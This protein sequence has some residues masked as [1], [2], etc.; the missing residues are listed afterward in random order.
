MESDEQLKHW[1]ALLVSW[2]N[3]IYARLLACL[4]VDCTSLTWFHLHSVTS[5]VMTSHLDWGVICVC[6]AFVNLLRSS[7][8]CKTLQRILISVNYLQIRLLQLW[9]WFE[10]NSVLRAAINENPM[11]NNQ[12]LIDCRS[13]IH[14][15]SLWMRC[16]LQPGASS[17]NTSL[18]YLLYWAEVCFNGLHF[19][20]SRI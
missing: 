4:F 9:I 18:P 5:Y 12:L 7:T 20:M 11:T 3:F 16:N 17:G 2:Q 19:I 10:D 6:I 8:G 14:P 1:D 15:K 13:E